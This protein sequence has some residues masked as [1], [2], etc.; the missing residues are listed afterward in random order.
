MGFFDVG[1]NCALC[2][3]LNARV[4]EGLFATAN[5]A[6]QMLSGPDFSRQNLEIFQGITKQFTDGSISKDEAQQQA[7]NIS[8]KLEL[9]FNRFSSFGIPALMLLVA[10]ISLYLQY[11]GNKAS[12]EDSAKILN[13][14][15]SHPY[16]V[17][18]LQDKNHIGRQGQPPTEANAT[19]KSTP[20]GSSV[21]RKPKERQKRRIARALRRRQL[22]PIGLIS[23]PSVF[24]QRTSEPPVA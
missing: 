19:K 11:E 3:S 16:S 14:L 23:A 21:E 2:G 4:S 22:A 5:N 10:L 1:T 15:L 24:G 20:V 7:R 12:S 13:A 6:I 8:P 9:L 17:Q 18:E